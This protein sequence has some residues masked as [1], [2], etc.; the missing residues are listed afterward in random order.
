MTVKNTFMAKSEKEWEEK[1]IHREE[2]QSESIKIKE[3]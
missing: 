1:K 3:M 2:I